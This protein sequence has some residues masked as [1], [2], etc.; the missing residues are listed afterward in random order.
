MSLERD[1][2]FMAIINKALEINQ[3]SMNKS[4]DARYVNIGTLLFN[5]Q[6]TLQD[7]IRENYVDAPLEEIDSSKYRRTQAEIDAEEDAKKQASAP[8]KTTNAS[9]QNGTKTVGVQSIDDD[10]E[11]DE[12]DDD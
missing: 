5:I 1:I 4:K 10:E 7:G 12:D 11:N 8:K 3:I 9:N 2:A 6:Q